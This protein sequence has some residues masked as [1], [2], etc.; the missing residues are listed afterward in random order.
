MLGSILILVG[1]ASIFLLPSS[2]DGK[3]SFC[4]S[5]RI[6]DKDA[7]DD[8]EDDD[9]D[10]DDDTDD[11]DDNDDDVDDDDDDVD[12]DDDDDDDFLIWTGWV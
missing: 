1:F 12:D 2:D 3:W 6:N 10:D 4:F 5:A 9:G 8:E 11:E 7:D